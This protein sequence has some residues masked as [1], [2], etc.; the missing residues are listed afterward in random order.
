MSENPFDKL[1]RVFAALDI[2]KGYDKAF[3]AR[4]DAVAQDYESRIQFLELYCRK[5]HVA[6][7]LLTHTVDRQGM[8]AQRAGEADLPKPTTTTPETFDEFMKREFGKR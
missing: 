3:K 5:H 4:M 8:E 7:Q 1:M 2:A 6:L